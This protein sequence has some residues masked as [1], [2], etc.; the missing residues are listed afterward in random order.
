[1]S[2]L[3]LSVINPALI[4]NPLCPKVERIYKC[5]PEH[6]G[7][8]SHSLWCCEIF[9]DRSSQYSSCFFPFLSC[10]MSVLHMS[11][12]PENW[13][14]TEKKPRSS[15]NHIRIW[16]NVNIQRQCRKEWVLNWERYFR[17]VLGK[18]LGKCGEL[19]YQLLDISVSVCGHVLLMWWGH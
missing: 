8:C 11:Q 13:N 5:S 14:K 4:I 2:K 12:V 17:A 6:R 7:Y 16:S 15:W 19:S 18:L 1:M 9:E 3:P 10:C